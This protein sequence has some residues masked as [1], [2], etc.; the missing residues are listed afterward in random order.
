VTQNSGV[1]VRGD[2]SSGN[3][4]CYGI[5]RNIISLEFPQQK[6]VILF[7]CD[8]Y[9]VPA[10]N[11]SRS[12]GYTRDKFGIIDIATSMF[13][14]SDEPYI[15]ASNAK[16]VFYVPIVDKPGCS[17][18]VLVRPRNLFFMQDTGNDAD[19]LDVGIQERIDSVQGQ[20]L[21]NWSRPDRAGTSGVADIINQV[22]R[23]AIAE[24][25]DYN[26]GDDS[27]DNDTYI[28]DGVI[29]PVMEEN[30]EDDDFLYS[31]EA[32]YSFI[33]LYCIFRLNCCK[34]YSFF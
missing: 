1:V 22:R 27:D 2:K 8:W 6:E 34:K 7:Q 13:R 24:P 21:S 32:L 12:R 17:T 23:E 29:A 18:V 11:T 25:D 30:I 15:L 5:I 4:T 14:Y 28:V 10:N 26:I 33:A 3:V 9:D 16:P 19:A 20:E 31:D